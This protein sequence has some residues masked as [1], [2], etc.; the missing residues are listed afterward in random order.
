MKPTHP[1]TGESVS[2]PPRGT[3]SPPPK[4][5]CVHS[6]PMSLPPGL[7]AMKGIGTK[8]KKPAGY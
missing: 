2:N 1:R 4:A 3:Y 5:E 8:I 6:P 7:K